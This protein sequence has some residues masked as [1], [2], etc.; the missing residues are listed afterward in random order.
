MTAELIDVASGTSLWKKSYDYLTAAIFKLWDELAT[1]IVDDGLH[2]RL[3]RDERREMLSR[4]TDNVEAFDLF[5]QGRRFQMGTSEDEYVL[6]RRAF[7]MAVDKDPRFAQAWLALGGTYWTSVLENYMAPIDA[8]PQVDRCLGQATALNPRL[9]DL[10][11]GRALK[12]FFGL[13]NWREADREWQ[14]AEA[15]P[16]SDIAPELLLTHALASWALGDSHGALRLARRARLID[17]L[18]PLLML[19]ESSYLLHTGQA[20]EAAALVLSVIQMHPDLS[21]AQFTLAEIRPRAGPLRR[22]D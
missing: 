8:W 6:A 22:G 18:S 2:L 20:D 9:P 12:T 10:N 3:T 19:H 1:A 4:P 7:Q 16:D 21:A 13:W 17:P 11:F 15:A 14:A 5:L